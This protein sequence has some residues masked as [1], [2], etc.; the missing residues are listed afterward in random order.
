[1]FNMI[2]LQ[3]CQDAKQTLQQLRGVFS[4]VYSR[5]FNNLI[6]EAKATSSQLDKSAITARL[7][8]IYAGPGF[9]EEESY[10]CAWQGL[11]AS[12]LS[13]D[14][15][16]Q[17]HAYTLS[18]DEYDDAKAYLASLAKQDRRLKAVNFIAVNTGNNIA[19]FIIYHILEN[20]NET[21]F[22]V[23]QSAMPAELITQLV[24]VLMANHAYAIFEANKANANTIPVL[25]ALHRAQ[26]ADAQATLRTYL[27][28]FNTDIR[29]YATKNGMTF[30]KPLNP[31]HSY[32]NPANDAETSFLPSILVR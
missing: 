18:V 22:Q 17:A 16:L 30:F 5:H 7:K 13:A 24:D 20:K 4:S 2:T 1:M 28:T 12:G 31:D 25:N 19:G 8:E 32:L 9:D 11:A 15:Y 10:M 6:A 23:R 29:H 14:D 26:L 27:R 3:D 21:I